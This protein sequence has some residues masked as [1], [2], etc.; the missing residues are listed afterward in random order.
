M[1]IKLRLISAILILS[2]I[3]PLFS[4]IIQPAFAVEIIQ[5]KDISVTYDKNTKTATISW[6]VQAVASG[7]ITYND[8][9]GV[10]PDVVILDPADITNKYKKIENIKNDIVYDFKIDLT[11]SSLVN[12]IGT[13]YF[14][15]QVSFTAE[16]VAQQ[17]VNVTGGGKET[18]VY[19]AI[20]L[21]WNMPKVYNGTAMVYVNEAFGTL[22]GSI[23]KMK[24]I[25][26]IPP[27][28][29]NANIEVT[30]TPSMYTAA[31][32]GDSTRV[33]Q[34]NF[35]SIT[36]KLSLYI[37]GVKDKDTAIPSMDDIIINKQDAVT[38]Q[39]TL[40]KGIPND[41]W[42]YVLPH[43]GVFPG[44]IYKIGMISSFVD[45]SGAGVDAVS[46]GLG[47]NPL[48]IGNPAMGTT[49][50][51]TYTPIRFQLTK[52]A[53]DNV[54]VRVQRIN[55]GDETLPKLYYEFQRSGVET[56]NDVSWETLTQKDDTYFIQEEYPIVYV[57]LGEKSEVFYRVIVY[58]DAKA[59]K[60]QS[61][62]L[63]YT[64]QDD[65][66]R[67]PV[68]KGISITNVALTFSSDT[69]ITDTS[70]DVTISWDKP[71]NWEQIK[72][73]DVYF[74]F[75]LS[76]S[77][78][79]LDNTPQIL[80][81]NGKN[82]GE[83]PVRYRLVK[84][85]SAQSDNIKE[86]TD[87]TKLVY[88]LKGFNL[89]T[90]EDDTGNVIGNTIPNT[91]TPDPYPTYLLP[92]KTYYMQMYT[93]AESDKGKAYDS[94]SMSEKSLVK[95]FTTLSQ[96]SVD[97]PI[98]KYLEWVDTTVNTS[99][100]P[101]NAT[102]K[103][104]FNDLNINWNNYTTNH[105]PAKDAVYY[106]LFMSTRTDPD[107]FVEIGTTQKPVLNNDVNFSTQILSNTTWFYATINKFTQINNPD[108]ISAFGYSLAPNTTYYFMVKVRLKIG[109][110]PET[111]N[112]KGSVLL[113]VTIPRGEPTTPDDS[114]EV[115]LAPTD[116][117][118]ALDKDGNP[119]VTG[120]T[121]TFEW[122]VQENEAFY[123][124]IATSKK[125]GADALTTD[126]SISDDPTYRSFISIFGNNVDG[127]KLKLDPNT[128]PLP[129]NLSYDS[130]TKKCRY[131]INTWLYPN[132][133]YYFSLNSESVDSKNKPV[134]SVWVSIPVT[135]ALIE[136][137]S[138][139]QVV[140][141]CELA[142]YWTDS[143]ERT[144]EDY[145]IR[146]KASSDSEYTLLSKAQY[147]IVKDESVF[148]GRIIKL[149]PD[150]QYSIQVLAST[151]DTV[152]RDFAMYTRD[153]YHQIEIKW[154]GNVLDTN[155][156]FE[157]AIKTE[158]DSDY[159]VLNNDEDLEKY[160]N[161]TT[162]T[163]PY[164]IEKS[165]SNLNN[166]YYTYNA[167]IKL[168]ETKLADGTTEHRPL[169]PNTKYYIKVRALKADSADSL[170][171]ARSKYVG[172]V[173][174]RTEFNQDDY[175][176]DDDGTN[177]SAKFLDMMDKLEQELF[178]EVNK[179]NSTLNK[180]Y[181]KD[182]KIVNLL[183]AAGYYSCTIDISQ[184]PDYSNNDEIY[185]AKNI[186]TAMKS[187]DKSVIIKT[188]AAEYT[189]RPETFDVD[190][191]EEFKNAKAASGSKDVYL[192]LNVTQSAD[193]QPNAP[194][195]TTVA[196]KM[197]VLSAQAVA[198]RQ[199]SDSIRVLIKDKIYNEKTGI[200]QKKLTIIKNP[201]NQ[202]TKGD[203]Q[204][205]NKYLN[206]LFEELK[207][208]LSY[209]IQD[210]LSGTGY[211]SGVFN[212]KYDIAKFNTP[213]AV[214]MP[215][216]GSTIANPYVLY[217]S[218][219]NWRKL[220]QN[221][222]YETGYLNYFVTGPGKYSIFSSKDVGAT[223]GDDNAAKPYISKLSAS[224]DLTSVFPGADVSFNSDLSVTVRE[225]ILLYELI[226]E[227][228]VDGQLDIKDKAKAYGIDKIINI[229]NV[230]RNITRQEAAAIITKLYCQK[231]G[232]DYDKLKASYSKII[233]DD[234]KIADRYAV[235]VYL[236]LQM[237]MMTLDSSANFNPTATINRAGI[238]M[239]LQKMLEA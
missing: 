101:A 3:F 73:N 180:V 49:T 172:P 119:M 71:N 238:V 144:V 78:K 143:P 6:S 4:G 132:K 46:V 202:G 23:E 72:N 109:D 88:T 9:V 159:T 54:Y 45:G 232:T 234:S 31:L 207:S 28:T 99:S 1:K 127:S 121:V 98:P 182:D 106:D 27:V 156:D 100:N 201:N 105:D 151:N 161:V 60:L 226:S 171:V 33:S 209:Y 123:N 48:V 92:N 16:Q 190:N 118:I 80:E 29:E 153:N 227:S 136:S 104:R 15:A 230:Y 218:T 229:T 145:K 97:V 191:M 120:Q 59:D 147:S 157:I 160:Y 167:R 122:T 68:P 77:E 66:A 79:D 17:P 197:N 212:E 126:E 128:N 56:T 206:Q 63:P 223:V 96:T 237:N 192:K 205:V 130:K 163:D 18:G 47:K 26:N 58:S 239:V 158:G 13:K 83:F 62:I 140:N 210:T 87:K 115:P 11:D 199:T 30:V 233:K 168:I 38:G 183:T 179:G 39:Y 102:V 164:Y 198:S 177:I 217:D 176:D 2:M 138:M 129:A 86:S 186:L 236:C 134:S 114:A 91:D 10:D 112:S 185:M 89:F 165:N 69:A 200:L 65:A 204:A 90:W 36:G 94:S 188:K 152:L 196:S 57:F 50:D 225:S 187:S 174:T 137:P 135:T 194:V 84:Y 32:A 142:F 14:L 189:I 149:K 22:D 148:Y 113:P 51:Y 224:Y 178:W 107:S 67:L 124:L 231:T 169:K 108:A 195:N 133:I 8:G 21:I 81:A 211:T 70:S 141:D 24:F 41:E 34:V 214:K 111:K 53:Y 181:V 35:N 117:S 139:L 170:A 146:L 173:D 75:L 228:G 175:D 82:Y 162:H 85:V 64:L 184:S 222:K 74:H 215:Y 221:L 42:Q 61:S 37:L 55:Q 43:P 125:V 76:V 116:F 203:A 40:P 25:F 154:Q 216:K 44:T 220:T 110:E 93:T 19:P 103:I 7:T 20:K 12:Y 166:N 219:G 5:S 235:P 155:S 131:T 208:E 213:L 95:S 193:I 150:T 52:D